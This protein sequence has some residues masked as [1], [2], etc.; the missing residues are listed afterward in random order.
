[1]RWPI[2]GFGPGKGIKPSKAAE[3]HEETVQYIERRLQSI[4][5]DELEK[6]EITA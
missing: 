6:Q 3:I 2:D 4:K 1:M 5:E